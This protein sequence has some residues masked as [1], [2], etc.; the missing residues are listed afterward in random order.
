MILRVI[1]YVGA[2]LFLLF[3]PATSCSAQYHIITMNSHEIPCNTL[4]FG[5]IPDDGVDD[6]AAIQRALDTCQKVYIPAGDYNIGENLDINNNGM[7]IFGDGIRTRLIKAE[8][9]QGGVI[10]IRDKTDVVV[11]NLHFVGP[12][13][14]NLNGSLAEAIAIHALYSQNITVSDN[15]FEGFNGSGVVR[16]SGD[17]AY[18]E[19]ERWCEN[20]TITNNVFSR[21]QDCAFDRGDVAANAIYLLSGVRDF[22]VENNVIEAS[23]QKVGI[24]VHSNIRNGVIKNNRVY[25]NGETSA[26]VHAYGIMVYAF[27]QAVSNDIRVIDNLV[28]NSA[29]MGIYVKGEQSYNFT[30]NNNTIKNC[31][32]ASD[33]VTLP[34]GSIS[35]NEVREVEI[36]GNNISGVTTIGIQIF[37]TGDADVVI[38]ENQISGTFNPVGTFSDQKPGGFAKIRAI[39]L[40]SGNN[41]LSNIFIKN[42]LVQNIQL[43]ITWWTPWENGALSK[44]LIQGNTI[45]NTERAISSLEFQDELSN[46]TNMRIA[47]NIIE[48]SQWGLHITHLSSSYISGNSFVRCQTPIRLLFDYN[49]IIENNQGNGFSFFGK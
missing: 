15:S 30:V 41:P 28:Q 29:N 12:G 43:G 34:A 6:V 9:G 22:R 2:A 26:S 16:F 39:T 20:I 36:K 3:L 32:Y 7:S 46:A 13:R 4:D 47:D 25:N 17:S 40:R 42:N 45:K 27:P 31:D 19:P 5:A 1:L 38:K 33:D 14:A 35:L 37:R 8:I 18:D 49:V 11:K 10:E 44:V 24:A 23:E 48:D 21:N